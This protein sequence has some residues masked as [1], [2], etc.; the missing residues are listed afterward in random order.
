MAIK[1]SAEEHNSEF[2]ASKQRLPSKDGDYGDSKRS[3]NRTYSGAGGVTLSDYFFLKPISSKASQSG[4]LSSSSLPLKASKLA[5]TKQI[6]RSSKKVK[7]VKIR[8]DASRQHY[9]Y[10]K[11]HHSNRTMS[12]IGEKQIQNRES[13]HDHFSP[14]GGGEGGGGGGGRETSFK[15][16]NY[17]YDISGLHHSVLLQPHRY[18]P[19]HWHGEA[20]NLPADDN[21]HHADTGARGYS[22]NDYGHYGHRRHYGPHQ[23]QPQ[24]I[25]VTKRFQ[26]RKGFT[27]RFDFF[28]TDDPWALFGIIACI[29]LALPL[30]K[31]VITLPISNV[32]NNVNRLVYLAYLNRNGTKMFGLRSNDGSGGGELGDLAEDGADSD[33]PMDWLQLVDALKDVAKKA[34]ANKL[35][36]GIN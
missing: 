14:G 36:A 9:D 3:Y 1:A 10:S 35:Q 24:N 20:Y 29:M 28:G 16:Y 21:R 4:K 25:A 8:P 17:P 15:D 12:S 30:L 19:D 33:M 2:G 26:R 22:H 34:I 11:S 5:K 23:Y 6:S 32:L 18:R 13:G 27:H 7:R 31:A